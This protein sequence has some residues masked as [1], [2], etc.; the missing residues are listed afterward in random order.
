MRKEIYILRRQ[1]EDSLA[2]IMLI[3]EVFLGWS[4]AMK[5][6]TFIKAHRTA[7]D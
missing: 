2:A 1:V 5:S 6:R 3:T 7:G 4:F